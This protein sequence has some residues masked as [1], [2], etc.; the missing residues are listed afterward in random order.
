VSG[1][2]HVS[3]FLTQGKDS[4]FPLNKRLVGSTASPDSLEKEKSLAPV[5]NLTPGRSFHSVITVLAGPCLL[6]GIGKEFDWHWVS[7]SGTGQQKDVSQL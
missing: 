6:L 5:W 7:N 4:L 1:Q 3:A 2:L